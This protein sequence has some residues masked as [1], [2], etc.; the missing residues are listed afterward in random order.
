MPELKAARPVRRLPGMERVAVRDPMGGLLK[1]QYVLPD[2]H[3]IMKG[4]VK[5]DDAPPNPNEQV[6]S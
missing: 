1:K 2:F 4:F 5:P 3:T 6:R